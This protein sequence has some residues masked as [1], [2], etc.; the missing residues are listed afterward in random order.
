MNQFISQIN[1]HKI[2]QLNLNQSNGQPRHDPIHKFYTMVV[3]EHSDWLLKIQPII[4]LQN[5][6]S[7]N[8][9]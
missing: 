7:V 6:H 4:V 8:M 3:F 1:V 9:R 2:K 5:E